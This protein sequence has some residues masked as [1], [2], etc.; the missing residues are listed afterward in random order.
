MDPILVKN[1]ISSTAYALLG[2]L[3]L[4]ISFVI[5]EK[6]APQNLWK[7]IVERQNVA[8]ALLAAGFMVAIALIISA[9]VHG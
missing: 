7:E 4:V 5:I 1:L 8:L 9:A 3:I 2:I 6:I